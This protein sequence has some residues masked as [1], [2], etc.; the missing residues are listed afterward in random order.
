V[1]TVPFLHPGWDIRLQS[2]F[3]KQAATTVWP[4]ESWPLWRFL[5]RFG[6]WPA[7]IVSVG[8]LAASILGSR[9][10]ALARWRRH[11][12]FLFLV[13]AI[14]PG[15]LVNTIFKDHWGRPRPRQVT[16]F[17]GDWQFQPFFEHGTPGRGKSFPCGHSS[18]GYYFVAF[19]F[20]LR[21]RH[22]ALA[23]LTLAGTAVY[24]SL[25]GIARMAAGAHFAS[26]VLWSAVF[27]ALAAYILYYFILRIPYHEDHPAPPK[28]LRHPILIGLAATLLATGALMAWLAGIPVFT[29]WH[30][31]IAYPQGRSPALHVAMERCDMELTL[32][33]SSDATVTIAGN[34]QGFGWPWSRIRGGILASDL[35]PDTLRFEIQLDGGFSELSGIVR[36]QAPASLFTEIEADMRDNLLTITAPDG[37]RTPPMSFRLTRSTL[38]L[39]PSQRSR[40]IPVAES[41]DVRELRLP[42]N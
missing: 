36:I 14:G 17:N 18:A 25:I 23:V 26:D 10:P 32:T 2:I 37:V 20:L 31:T 19:Y 15:L 13:L 6:T 24:G 38:T 7:L 39:P 22:K 12:L 41:N 27:P 33:D 28:P 9:R 40:L 16:E 4:L 8:A 1:A 5:Y 35:K 11:F 30:K 3:Y 34:A 21:R 29:E 42:G